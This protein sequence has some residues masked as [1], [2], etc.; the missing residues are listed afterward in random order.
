MRLLLRRMPYEQ[1]NSK[2]AADEGDD[3]EKGAKMLRC[4]RSVMCRV[5]WYRVR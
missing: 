5:V 4:L 2:A 1:I 3:N